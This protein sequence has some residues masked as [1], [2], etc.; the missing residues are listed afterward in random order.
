MTRK[1]KKRVQLFDDADDDNN[2]MCVYTILERMARMT[3]STI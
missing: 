2:M 1:E 3:P